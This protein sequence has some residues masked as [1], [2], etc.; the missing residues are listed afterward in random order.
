M[1]R[2]FEISSA[3]EELNLR[4]PGPMEAPDI[5]DGL[6][7][8]EDPGQEAAEE[9]DEDGPN[10]MTC[11]ICLEQTPLADLAL[12][13]GCEHQYC[14][15]CILMWAVCK[16][17]CPQCKAPFNY[18][19]TY[20]QLDGNITDYPTEES[21]CLLKRAR[22][23]EDYVKAKE[24]GRSAAIFRNPNLEDELPSHGDW[25]DL[26]EDMLDAEL[27]EDEEIESYYFSSAA[28]RARVVLGNRRL[29]EGGYMRS[30][31]VYA[32]PVPCPVTPNSSVKQQRGGGKGAAAGKG[33]VGPP[34]SPATPIPVDRNSSSSNNGAGSSSGAPST[35]SS[36]GN[37][38]SKGKNTKAF[39]NKGNNKPPRVAPDFPA[40]SI[41]G[42]S[43]L[44]RSPSLG[45]SPGSFSA[46]L[47]AG[48]SP[49]MPAE[50]GSGRRAKRAAR[51]MA[52]DDDY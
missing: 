24:C 45:R 51:R 52:A 27:E 30:G 16:E 8:A 49:T 39:K 33:K 36:S 29:G 31:R 7:A 18:L 6:E 9:A 28:G 5:F 34:A 25:A 32:R 10:E 41:Y 13:K 14:V 26:Y 37:S 40:A 21:V 38:S 11:A 4:N 43:P 15:N 50:P 20:R 23:F 1:D 44:G 2:S 12:I 47:A 22:W 46:M 48:T 19:I 42:S 17:T 35:S 3:M